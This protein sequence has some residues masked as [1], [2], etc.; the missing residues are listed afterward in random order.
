METCYVT[1]TMVRER[2][3]MLVFIYDG[4]FEGLLTAIYEAYY[5]GPHPD[6]IIE[7]ANMQ[8]NLL[9][10]F[11]NIQTDLVKSGKV[12]RSIRE[13]ISEEALEHVYHVY[14][15]EDEDS[16]TMIYNYLKL[17]WKLGGKVDLNLADDR[18]LKVHE[19][20]RRV[21]HEGQRLLGFVR[22]S[23]VEGGI[24]Y[25]S[26]SPDYNVVELLAPHFAERLAIQPWIIHDVKRGTAA[27]YNTRDW[28]VTD[29]DS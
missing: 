12:Y 13:K 15:S 3:E 8:F 22:F 17:G 10:E 5:T 4:S 18:V 25:A 9:D 2:C 20:S 28:I 27:L 11:R 1:G 19:L 29:F 7:S 14:L 6:R 26:I 23:Q 24:Y 16:G 21:E